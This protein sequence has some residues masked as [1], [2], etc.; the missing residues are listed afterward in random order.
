MCLDTY[1]DMIIYIGRC[2]VKMTGPI[3]ELYTC[4]FFSTIQGEIP[5]AEGKKMGIPA[6]VNVEDGKIPCYSKEVTQKDGIGIQQ[7]ALDLERKTSRK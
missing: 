6:A 5:P 7:W 4:S 1:I 2:F 3:R